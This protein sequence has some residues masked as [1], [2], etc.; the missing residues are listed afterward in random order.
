MNG[1]REEKPLLVEIS[2]L[3]DWA[4]FRK[5]LQSKMHFSKVR[6]RSWKITLRIYI[7]IYLIYL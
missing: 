1:V 4:D 7:Y 2:P 6:R 3:E 5:T